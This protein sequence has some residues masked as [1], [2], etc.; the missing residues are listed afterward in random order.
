M[1]PLWIAVTVVL[2]AG[3]G[4]LVWQ[5]TRLPAVEVVR[6][7]P[8]PVP[9]TITTP[10]AVEGPKR[11]ELSLKQPGIV[12]AV[13]AV[14]G[15][16]YKK[17][18]VL[19][20]LISQQA[21][22]ALEEAERAVE[23]ARGDVED[24]REIIRDTPAPAVTEADA[25]DQEPSEKDR[26]QARLDAAVERV[27]QLKRRRN[28]IAARMKTSDALAPFD[29]LVIDVFH[30]EGQP[31]EPK[32]PILLLAEDSPPGIRATVDPALAARL[33][34]GQEALITDPLRPEDTVRATVTEY[35]TRDEDGKPTTT[36]RLRPLDPRP[37]LTDKAR[38]DVT[39]AVNPNRKLLTVP[40]AALVRVG[41]S[42]FVMVLDQSTVVRREVK[43]G[44]AVGARA[45]V[46]SG[47][48]EFDRVVLAPLHVKEGQ[49]VRG[50]EVANQPNA[51]APAA[52]KG[53]AQNAG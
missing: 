14:K 26:L 36:I 30:T 10:G 45:A 46:L 29:V 33:Q 27:D 3:A 18:E 38:V 7:A 50:T 20:Q 40:A 23:E 5:V 34:P 48:S 31:V 47:L 19:A 52:G 16:R 17:G 44:Q 49:R 2:V 6:P 21:R 8:L 4:A 41:D 12:Q 51:P 43:P 35:T 11:V 22:D 39:I 1:R 24:L 53:E 9:E 25:D 37:G 28:S 13:L 42:A 32:Q 15:E